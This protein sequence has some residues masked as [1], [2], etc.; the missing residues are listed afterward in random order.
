[1]T[2]KKLLKV[3]VIQAEDLVPKR[4][5]GANA[6]VAVYF[7]DEI[8]TTK[9]ISEMPSPIWNEQFNLYFHF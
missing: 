3:Y 8:A 7:G 6:A 4:Y 2:S 1:M 5:E 9:I